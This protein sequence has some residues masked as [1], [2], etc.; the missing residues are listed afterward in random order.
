[1]V[2]LD[3]RRSYSL[4]THKHPSVSSAS[5]EVRSLEP[6]TNHRDDILITPLDRLDPAMPDAPAVAN[7]CC[8]IFVY[9]DKDMS[10]RHLIGLIKS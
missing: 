9:T 4:Y 5:L 7:P 8:G 1:M 2:P 6:K 3:Q 10:I